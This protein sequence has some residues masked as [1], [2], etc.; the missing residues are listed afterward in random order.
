MTIIEKDFSPM[1][2]IWVAAINLDCAKKEIIPGGE[3]DGPFSV[4]LCF[5]IQWNFSRK[6]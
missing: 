3:L 5:L 4:T 1:S 6:C 2:Q